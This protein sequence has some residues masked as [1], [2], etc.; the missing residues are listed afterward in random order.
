V[1]KTL[2]LGARESPQPAPTDGS[3][4]VLRQRLSA[5]EHRNLRFRR[6]LHRNLTGWAFIAPFGV[7]FVAFLLIPVLG[8][9]YWSTRSG[10]LTTAG[11]F[12]GLKNFERVIGSLEASAAVFNTAAFAVQSVPIIILVALGLAALLARV[13]R[14]GAVYRFLIYFPVLVPGVVVG[15]IWVFLTHPDFGMFNLLLQGLGREPVTWLGIDTALTMVVAADIWRNVGYWAIFF[16]AAMLGLPRELYEAAHLDG[17]GLW[18]RFR[19]VTLP[20]IRRIVLL[21]VVMATIWALQVF[22]IVL[23]LTKGGPGTA[24][25]T[26]VYYVW[27]YVFSRNKV[28]MGAA[29]S[30]LLLLVILA[31]SLVLLRLMRERRAS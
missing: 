1:T 7:F 8:V 13:R 9:F 26:A 31:L 10:T 21:A 25:T 16:L 15:L 2:G 20:G 11:E 29:I 19:Y 22:D 4:R 5:R 24:T 27:W 3:R 12:V 14:G 30:V 23:I 17:A 18:Q 28:G 6:R